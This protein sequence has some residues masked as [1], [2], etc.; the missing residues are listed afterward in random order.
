MRKSIVF[1]LMLTIAAQGAWAWYG[2]TRLGDA[3]N[4]QFMGPWVFEDVANETGDSDVKQHS[5]NSMDYRESWGAACNGTG[6]DEKITYQVNDENGLGFIMNCRSSW[7]PSRYSVYSLYLHSE[8]VPAYT[9]KRLTWNFKLHAYSNR[10]PQNVALYA[11]DNM[12]DMKSTVVD[13]THNYGNQAGSA[14]RIGDILKITGE[15]NE[16]GRRDSS[17]VLHTHTFD[18]DNR[19]GS[20]AQEKTW[21]LMLTHCVKNTTSYMLEIF[22]WGTFKDYGYTWQ[23]F[24]YKYVTFDANGGEGTMAEQEI[25]N[26]GTLTAN[27]F[28]RDNHTFAGWATSANGPV[29]YADA[30]EITANEYSKGPVTLYAVW[31]R[32]NYFISYELNGG[33]ATNPSSYTEATETFTLANPTRENSTF[34]GWVGSNGSTPE[35]TVTIAQGS[36]G[37][38]TFIAHWSSDAVT[39]A[40]ALIDAIGE[41][42]H[43]P[44]SKAKIDAARA[45]YDALT[46]GEKA[47]VPAS[48]LETLRIAEATFAAAEPSTIRFMEQDGQTQVGD[49]QQKAIYY[50]AFPAGASKW[51]TEQKDASDKTIVIKAMSE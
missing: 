6:C 39:N 38:K 13:F 24:Y 51:Q 28:T 19:N 10:H 9:R 45:A 49:D 30:A 32:V 35:M 14:Y 21:V 4:C 5:F 8:S 42:E 48:K 11:R 33:T 34:L 1:A 25:E 3:G 29:V 47:D 12:D 26:S 50:P 43:T 31:N 17:S 20:N 41:V 18:F 37:D 27:A 16:V 15:S 22:Q 36:T 46:A 7:L 23:T 44:E 40:L 2:P